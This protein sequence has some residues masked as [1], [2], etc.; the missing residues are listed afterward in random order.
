MNTNETRR[1]LTPA[2]LEQR[3]AR[4][5]D[6]VRPAYL[7]R[8][9]PVHKMPQAIEARA[10]YDAFRAEHG[11]GP[12]APLLSEDIGKTQKND[13][14]TYALAFLPAKTSGLANV[15]AF[16][17][18]CAAT[19]VAFSG[20][21]GVQS[22]RDAR[23][24]RL[25]FAI[26]NPRA[27]AWLLTA[28]LAK[29]HID[30][31]GQWWTDHA[32]QELPTGSAAPLRLVRLNAYSDLRWE[33][34][35]GWLL[36]DCTAVGFYDYTKHTTR[37]R[38]ATDLPHNYRLTYSVS[39]RSTLAEVRAAV[40][41]GRN[42]AVVFAA[43]AH[44]NHDTLPATWAGLEVIDG[45]TTDDRYS[46]PVA[47]VVGLRRKGSMTIAG[48]L[49]Q[50]GTRLGLE[51]SR[52]AGTPRTLDHVERRGWLTYTAPDG[53]EVLRVEGWWSLSLDG[54]SVVARKLGGRNRWQFCS[55][56]DVLTFEEAK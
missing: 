11:H 47:V 48:D 20:K 49:V 22:V 18:R 36:R 15:C 4:A 35:C 12:G 56:A 32:G 31:V 29:I 41:A 30:A 28:E 23:W 27:F 33:R 44:S 55:A 19:C 39:R 37:S 3:L 2:Q 46:D 6:R 10:A 17:D 1:P 16:E 9:T 24:V 7:L 13:A 51:A 42:A 5:F 26:E 34:V 21:G 38:P 43:R 14:R 53:I 25:A 45:D 8:T 40:R 52:N 54:R 50:A